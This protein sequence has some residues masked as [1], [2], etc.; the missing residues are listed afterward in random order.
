MIAE[1][2]AGVIEVAEAVVA[3]VAG[4]AAETAAT[5]TMTTIPSLHL[6]AT[7]QHWPAPL[8]HRPML[9]RSPILILSPIRIHSLTHLDQGRVQD[10]WHQA[11]AHHRVSDLSLEAGRTTLQCLLT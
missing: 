6:A 1:V 7:L 3:E 2:V 5:T 4:Q 10:S 9:L 11:D 8:S